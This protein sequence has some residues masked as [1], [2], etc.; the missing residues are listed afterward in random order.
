M[1]GGEALVESFLVGGAAIRSL[2]RDP[3]LPDEIAPGDHRRALTDA[4][5]DYDRRGRALWNR[6]LETASLDGTPSHALEQAT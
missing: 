5:R 4:M 1:A 2:A 6:A 3:L